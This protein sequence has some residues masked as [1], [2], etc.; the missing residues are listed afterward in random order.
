MLTQVTPKASPFRFMNQ[1]S[2]K[3]MLGKYIRLPP[4]A[5][6]ILCVMMRCQTLVENDAAT[7]EVTT[8]TKPMTTAGRR[9]PGQRFI[10]RALTGAAKQIRPAAVL[11]IMAVLEDPSKGRC[12]L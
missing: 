11:P 5:K 3:S 6:R 8:I 9:N 10:T 4:T 2:R 12:M 1:P 7:R